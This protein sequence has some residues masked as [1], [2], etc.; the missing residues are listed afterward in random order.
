M[1]TRP[2]WVFNA[3]QRRPYFASFGNGLPGLNG[4]GILK[5][6]FIGQRGT[7]EG[8]TLVLLISWLIL[9]GCFGTMYFMDA[10]TKKAAEQRLRSAAP[11]AA[12]RR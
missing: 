8:F 1:T 2:S 12:R 10:A 11:E 4:K 7:M 6:L 3:K 5:K 9:V